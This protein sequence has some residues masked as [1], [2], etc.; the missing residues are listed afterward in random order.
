MSE[1]F[2]I[3]GALTCK[4]DSFEP[5]GCLA[6]A[7]YDA[8][9]Y[10][11]DQA[12][13]VGRM[14]V[15]KQAFPVC[16]GGGKTVKAELALGEI[17]IDRLGQGSLHASNSAS[18]H[19]DQ[20]P[21]AADQVPAPES[22][23]RGSVEEDELPDFD[24]DEVASVPTPPPPTQT[25]MEQGM[26]VPPPPTADNLAPVVPGLPDVPPISVPPSAGTGTFDKVGEEFSVGRSG[27][28]T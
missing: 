18:P 9:A 3:H 25:S 16:H 4:S 26:V 14:L 21:P 23:S 11:Q 1:S 22:H 24:D 28:T 7:Y 5:D 13:R 6:P 2:G 19:Q 15:P 27:F 17:R 20:A 10:S 12:L 8:E